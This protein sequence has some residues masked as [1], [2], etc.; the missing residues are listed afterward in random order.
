MRV[1]LLRI[2]IPAM[3]TIRYGE[4]LDEDN[5]RVRFAG[6]HRPMRSLG[7]AVANTSEPV[8]ADVDDWQILE[9]R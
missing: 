5:P 2:Q 9:V 1:Q 8:Y 4:G 6:D 7:Q 3:S